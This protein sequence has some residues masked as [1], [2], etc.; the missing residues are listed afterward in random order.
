MVPELKNL[1]PVA[2]Q[3]LLPSILRKVGANVAT[4]F[5]NFPNVTS[6]EQVVEQRRP[7]VGADM[8]RVFH[9][10]INHDYRYLALPNP[11]RRQAHL[12]E[13]RT[14]T[15]GRVVTS[16]GDDSGYMITEGFVST[17]V[18]FAAAYQPESQ[19]RYLGQQAIDRRTMYVVAF[20]QMPSAQVKEQ[21]AIGNGKSLFVLTQGLAWIDP[22]NHQIVRM[23]TGLMEP[24][25]EIKLEAQTTRVN[26]IEVHFQGM[27]SGL[28]LPRKVEVEMRWP[29]VI[30]RDFHTYSEF[31][32]FTVHTQERQAAPAAPQ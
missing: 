11:D 27:T 25:P 9:D 31:K 28:W 21:I 17:P 5:N 20:A 29:G 22:A 8:D 14:D 19:F 6:H 4:L 2:S 26:F 15:K 32:L 12:K 24:V 1:Q 10:E 23:W 30:F 13:Y 16:N 3:D 7:V 18:F